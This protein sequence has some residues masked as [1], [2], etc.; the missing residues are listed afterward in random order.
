MR[1]SD[2]GQEDAQL[3]KHH[4]PTLGALT[5][6]ERASVDQGIWAAPAPDS[7]WPQVRQLLSRGQRDMAV[8][9]Q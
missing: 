5:A 8:S 6:Q 2:G 3:Q 9:W 1:P 7:A 4:Q